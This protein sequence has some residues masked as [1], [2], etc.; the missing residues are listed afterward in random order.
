MRLGILLLLLAS[1]ACYLDFSR[2]A[3]FM[4][5]RRHQSIEV[6]GMPARGDVLG[7]RFTAIVTTR[8]AGKE[9]SYQIFPAGDIDMTGDMGAVRDCGRWVAPRL[10]LLMVIHPCNGLGPGRLMGN[11]SGPHFLTEDKSTVQIN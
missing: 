11:G 1:L 9:H 4:V 6:N 8:D 2:K 7:G 3:E 5:L 10:P